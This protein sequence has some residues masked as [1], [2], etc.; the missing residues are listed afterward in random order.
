[1]QV[2]A[3]YLAFGALVVLGVGALPRE[4]V[5]ILGKHYAHLGPDAPY[6]VGSAVLSS[7]LALMWHMNAY[8]GWVSSSWIYVPA[9]IV[10][11]V[12]IIPLLELSSVRGVIIFGALSAL[13]ALAI[14]SWLAA[15]GLRSEPDTG[16]G[17][18]V[19]P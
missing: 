7:L 1:V 12:L 19:A 18:S 9:T 6:A 5:W 8:R 17:G 14:S 15:R 11:Q 16:S 3:I 2:V 13:P 4:A 10:V